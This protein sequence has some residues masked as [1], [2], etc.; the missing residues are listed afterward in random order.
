M[1]LSGL[2]GRESTALPVQVSHGDDD[3]DDVD[4]DDRNDDDDDHIAYIRFPNSVSCK[5]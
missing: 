3:D 2:L 4:D 1:K 5:Y